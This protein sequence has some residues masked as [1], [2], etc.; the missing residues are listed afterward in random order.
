MELSDER[1]I[2]PLRS[3]H[4]ALVATSEMHAYYRLF[5]SYERIKL[6][7]K[8]AHERY[9]E[10]HQKLSSK[11]GCSYNPLHTVRGLKISLYF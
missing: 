4:I 7:I 6:N 1:E 8:N 3:A 9:D 11:N 2:W 5:L 10:Y